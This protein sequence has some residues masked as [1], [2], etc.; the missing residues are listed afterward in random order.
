MGL[1]G[2]LV[3]CVRVGLFFK[4]Q[5]GAILVFFTGSAFFASAIWGSLAW[6]VAFGLLLVVGIKTNFS[7]GSVLLFV[8]VVTRP[9]RLAGSFDAMSVRDENGRRAP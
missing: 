9:R 6:A 1:L 2:T 7:I 3:A 4:D 8:L 5:L